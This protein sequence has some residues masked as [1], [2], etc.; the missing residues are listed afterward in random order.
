[1][2][3]YYRRKRQTSIRRS[4]ISVPK[5]FV[6]S[7]RH[8][9]PVL[10]W[11]ADN[12]CFRHVSLKPRN[13]NASSTLWASVRDPF[14]THFLPRLRCEGEWQ[15]PTRKQLHWRAQC[16]RLS[17]AC[18]DRHERSGYHARYSAQRLAC[19]SLQKREFV[20]A[21]YNKGDWAE[22]VRQARKNV[23]L[24]EQ[25]RAA[26]LSKHDEPDPSSLD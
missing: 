7:S 1:M 15:S 24:G 23:V 14:G 21:A 18:G 9:N 8:H 26:R 13:T 22:T 25:L 19:R 5:A 3:R 4:R 16:A 11:T 20:C 2:D 6:L 10:S 12:V 17:C